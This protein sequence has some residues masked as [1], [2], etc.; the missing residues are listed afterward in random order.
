M[1]HDG[2][3]DFTVSAL[4]QTEHAGMHACQFDR[5]KD[6]FGDNLARAR[7]GRVA[8]NHHRTTSR[9]R[10]RRVTARRGERQREV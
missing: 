4:D 6:G 9:Q 10:S 5:R 8:L 3:A 1:L 7:V 2:C